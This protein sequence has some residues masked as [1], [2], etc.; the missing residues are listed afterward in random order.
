MVV[1]PPGSKRF[2]IAAGKPLPRFKG[3]TSYEL[4]K[5]LLLIGPATKYAKV[6]MPA[7]IPASAGMTKPDMFNCQSNNT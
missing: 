7:W 2:V 1:L 4:K 6:V 5:A 3:V